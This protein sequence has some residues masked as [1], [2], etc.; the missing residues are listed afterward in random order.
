M[1]YINAKQKKVE[2]LMLVSDKIYFKSKTVTGNSEDHYIMIKG[3]IHQE[4]NCKHLC[5]QHKFT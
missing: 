3:L 5:T 2:E 1:F 4:D